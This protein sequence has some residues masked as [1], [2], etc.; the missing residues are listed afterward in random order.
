MRGELL[1][2]TESPVAYDTA[3]R[4]TMIWMTENLHQ[5][6]VKALTRWTGLFALINNNVTSRFMQLSAVY[7]RQLNEFLRLLQ[8]PLT[9]HIESS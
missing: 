5:H 6:H 7:I 2:E 4:F 3:L 9:T 8:L 1:Q